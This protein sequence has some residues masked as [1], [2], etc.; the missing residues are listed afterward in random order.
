MRKNGSFL[1]ILLLFFLILSS[2]FICMENVRAE[3]QK[4]DIYLQEEDTK[5]A[6]EIIGYRDDLF[7][8]DCF[9]R[10]YIWIVG[11][12]GT[13]FS[14]KTAGETWCRQESGTDEALYNVSFVDKN[15]GWV[16]G[17]NGVILHTTNGG[18]KWELQNSATNEPLF[19]VKFIDREHGWASGRFGTILYTD[20][21]GNRWQDRSI[22]EVTVTQE[23]KEEAK[24]RINFYGLYCINNDVWVVGEFGKIFHTS[25][26]GKDWIPQET[27]ANKTLFDVFFDYFGDV[28]LGYVVGIDGLILH[29]R[30]GGATW[31]Q[32]E[33][34]TTENLF[35]VTGGGDFALAVGARGT[36]IKTCDW[37]D[38][39]QEVPDLYSH[40]DLSGVALSMRIRQVVGVEVWIVGTH[41]ELLT[42]VFTQCPPGRYRDTIIIW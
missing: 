16:V 39:W 6:N 41:G 34:G 38:H 33:S 14:S 3:N 18:K 37:G 22:G 28:K 30:D 10:D 31:Y 9:A 2:T 7:G 23:E 21:G 20:N 4:E 26:G 19:A 8:I 42:K 27:G 13:I 1:K 36:M 17:D 15:Y 12:W 25:N 24:K 40:Q 11:Y 32:Q 5:P 29:T 35:A